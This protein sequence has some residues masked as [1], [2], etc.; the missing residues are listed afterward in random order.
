M[1]ARIYKP[2]RHAM[3]SG[4]AKTHQWVLEFDPEAPRH[5]EPLMGWPATTDTRSQ[6]RLRFRSK[7]DAIA[8]AEEHGIDYV[9]LP[10]HEHR[11]VIRPRGY[12]DNFAPERRIA[13]TH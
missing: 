9:V 11:H 12:G 7:E 2:A 5:R 4:L 8:Y 13:W 1:P 6:I 3:Q 10:P